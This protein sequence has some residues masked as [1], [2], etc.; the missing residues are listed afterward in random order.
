MTRRGLGGWRRLAWTR[1]WLVLAAVAGMWQAWVTWRPSPFLP[2]PAAIAARVYQEWFSG[3]PGRL[4][5]TPAATGNLLP[6]LGRV[7]AGLAISTVI[8]VPLGLAIG[9]SRV[10]TALLAPV[11]AYA[12][13]V[14]VVTAAPVFL[15]VFGIGTPME[16]AVITAGTIWP[17]LASTITGAAAAEPLYLETARVFRLRR[18]DRLLR[19]LVPAAL[20]QILAGLRLSLSLALVLMVYAE[21]TGASDGLGY[22]LAAA[23]GSFDLTGAWAVLMLLAILGYLASTALDA[24]GRRLLRGQPGS[25][26]A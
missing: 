5:L 11:L 3:P 24:A 8:G 21:L 23:T 18:R 6:S 9:R 4:F 22:Q 17:L 14:P 1:P 2:P 26:G 20:P 19:V 7:A 10:I 15:A 12:R 13:A 16:I 25:R